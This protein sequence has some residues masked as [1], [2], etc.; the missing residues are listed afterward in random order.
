MTEI[1]IIKFEG[2]PIE[3]L[4]DTIKDFFDPYLMVKKAKAV[5]KLSSYVIKKSFILSE[6]LLN[7]EFITTDEFLC[8]YRYIILNRNRCPYCK[9][10]TRTKHWQ[11]LNKHQ[12]YKQLQYYR[13]YFNSIRT[14]TFNFGINYLKTI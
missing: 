3:K 11:S 1:N 14:R 6:P 7:N 12:Y 5:Q 13:V 8:L 4:L 9:T 10:F 2:K